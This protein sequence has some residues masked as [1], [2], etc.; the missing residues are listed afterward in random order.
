MAHKLGVVTHLSSYPAEALGGLT[1]GVTPLEM[2]DVYATLADGGWRNTPIAI[3][4]VRFPDGHV[5]SSWGRPHRVKVLSDGVTAEETSILEQNVQSGTAVRSA[6][7][8]AR[9][10]PDGTTSELVDAWLDGYTP[11]TRRSCGWATNR[12]VS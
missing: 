2:A 11:T 8:P 7:S 9:R 5:D 4:R 12:R 3:T 10:R 6:I 1:L